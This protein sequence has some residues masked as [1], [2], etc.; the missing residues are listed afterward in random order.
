MSRNPSLLVVAIIL[1]PLF[2]A[3]TWASE[4]GSPITCEDMVVT[5][6]TGLEARGFLPRAGH[7]E[8][9]G[10]IFDI[11]TVDAAGNVYLIGGSFPSVSGLQIEGE[12][13][14]VSSLQIEGE[15]PSVSSLLWV[16]I[17]PTGETEVILKLPN[18]R[19]FKFF[20]PSSGQ[21][22]DCLDVVGQFGGAFDTTNGRMYIQFQTSAQCPFGR[23]GGYPFG[24]EMCLVTGFGTL[25]EILE[26]QIGGDIEDLRNR[27]DQISELPTIIHLLEKIE[28]LEGTEGSIP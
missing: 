14:S 1:V 13:P 15:T 16:R 21:E 3:Q 23:F 7:G 17:S 24:W 20:D 9:P 27:L 5:L 6:G 22:F 2:S 12:T 25:A 19:E 10:F 26:G 18:F 4:P 11:N 8:V 28:R